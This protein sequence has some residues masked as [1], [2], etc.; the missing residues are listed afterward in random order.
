[1]VIHLTATHGETTG[2]DFGDASSRVILD[3]G[4]DLGEV[5]IDNVSLTTGHTGTEFWVTQGSASGPTEPA[6][7]G[8]E[9][10]DIDLFIDANGAALAGDP[11]KLENGKPA[12]FS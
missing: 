1:M 2:P 7:T 5:N 4:A 8:L 12:R 6:P 9:A 10:Q 3:M 11:S